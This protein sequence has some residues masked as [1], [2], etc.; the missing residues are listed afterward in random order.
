MTPTA[1]LGNVKAAFWSSSSYLTLSGNGPKSSSIDNGYPADLILDIVPSLFL[2]I[3]SDELTDMCVPESTKNSAR[4]VQLQ[5]RTEAPL[6][7]K[8]LFSP[9][10]CLVEFGIFENNTKFHPTK[11][12]N[13]RKEK[14]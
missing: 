7:T 11:W 4:D 3:R 8:L 2:E 1:F 12:K 10:W 13:F 9:V 6:Y 14:R 5:L